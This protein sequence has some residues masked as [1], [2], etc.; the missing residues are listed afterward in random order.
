MTTTA[1]DRNVMH[2]DS[3]RE[4]PNKEKT[5]IASS[6]FQHLSSYPSEALASTAKIYG[7][8]ALPG[9]LLRNC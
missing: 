3:Y 6:L 7:I 4:I 5:T 1:E 2:T 9:V 8:S